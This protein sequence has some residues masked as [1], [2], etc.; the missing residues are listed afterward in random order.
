MKKEES[1]KKM[2]AAFKKGKTSG[3]YSTHEESSALE[4]KY[5][6]QRALRDKGGKSCQRC[7]REGTSMCGSCKGKENK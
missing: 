1:A 6:E 5:R 7:G 4:K 3:N 2:T